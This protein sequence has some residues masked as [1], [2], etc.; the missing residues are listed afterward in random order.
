MFEKITIGPKMI[1]K[2]SFLNTKEKYGRTF[3]FV[4]VYHSYRLND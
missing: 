4:A 2:E 1:M 3:R